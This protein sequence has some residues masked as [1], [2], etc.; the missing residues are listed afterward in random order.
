[1]QILSQISSSF[2]TIPYPFYGAVY[3]VPATE[4]QLVLGQDLYKNGGYSIKGIY[5]YPSSKQNYPS[6]GEEFVEMVNC[7]FYPNW[8]REFFRYTQAVEQYLKEFPQEHIKR[9][10]N[11]VDDLINHP[12]SKTQLSHFLYSRAYDMS[13][14]KIHYTVYNNSYSHYLNYIFGLLSQHLNIPILIKEV[15]Q[16]A[17][18]VSSTP[19][20]R[21]VFDTIRTIS[22]PVV[23]DALIEFP[24]QARKIL[25]RL[26][27]LGL[28]IIWLY[29]VIK[30]FSLLLHVV[31]ITSVLSS[32]PAFEVTK[33]PEQHWLENLP[34]DDKVA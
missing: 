9:V 3:L 12:T 6:M 23:I 29:M 16:P 30:A 24:K 18:V 14:P 19:R 21:R 28:A 11:Q 25:F 27:M 17:P 13:L 31:G 32:P 34:H 33:L 2:S 4:L 8:H 7:Y 5:L 22:I 10:Y 20:K 1:M 15:E 26:L